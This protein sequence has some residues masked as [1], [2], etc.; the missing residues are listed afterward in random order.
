[1]CVIFR[2]VTL[3]YDLLSRSHTWVVDNNFLKYKCKE[4]GLNF[5]RGSQ[6][7]RVYRLD[8]NTIHRFI[9]SQISNVVMNIFFWY[10]DMY[11]N[12]LIVVVRI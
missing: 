7:L 6:N 11:V 8:M 12:V 3:T 1:M 9:F 2:Y 5:I 10:I 4:G